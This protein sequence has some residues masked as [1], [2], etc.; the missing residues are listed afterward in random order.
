MNE[1]FIE[2]WTAQGDILRL[3]LCLRERRRYC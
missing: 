1:D 2:G 3:D